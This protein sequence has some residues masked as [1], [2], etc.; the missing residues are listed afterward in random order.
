M[1]I[2][3]LSIV[4]DYYCEIFIDEEIVAIAK[5]NE[6]ILLDI[7]SGKHL[8]KCVM[9]TCERVYIEQEIEIV[10]DLSLEISF[11]DHLFAH[12]DLIV[13]AGEFGNYYHN[14]K[15]FH[16]IWKD[17]EIVAL[18]Q[19]G[20]NSDD[21]P[22]GKHIEVIKDG[23]HGY[24]NQVGVPA[25]DKFYVIES[26]G[27]YGI[28]RGLGTIVCPCVYDE[29]DDSDNWNLV[30]V[31][32]NGLW[33]VYDFV[34]E[35][36]VQE[37]KY[38]YAY[39]D[40][41]E[42]IV[43]CGSG[44]DYVIRHGDDSSDF[45]SIKIPYYSGI[46][47]NLIVY[48]ESGQK[49][50]I[51]FNGNQVL[52]PQYHA[53]ESFDD[54]FFKLLMSASWYVD[55][56]ETDARIEFNNEYDA[57]S[58]EVQ[59]KD[60][61]LI[62]GRYKEIWGL[63]DSNGK[64]L[65]EKGYSYIDDIG[66]GMLRVQRNEKWGCLNENGEEAIPCIYDMVG[67][68]SFGRA[69]VMVGNKWGVM[70]MSGN[71]ILPCELD[72]CPLFMQGQCIISRSGKVGVIDV[73]GNIVIPCEYDKITT[74]DYGRKTRE[75]LIE[76]DFN[77]YTG[78]LSHSFHIPYY[79]WNYHHHKYNHY[80]VEKYNSWGL[81]DLCGTRLLPYIYNDFVTFG[82]EVIGIKRKGNTIHLSSTCESF[83]CKRYHMIDSEHIL[84]DNNGRWKL[85]KT[86]GEQI[87]D[88]EFE[89]FINIGFGL[90]GLKKDKSY[91]I[92]NLSE[93]RFVSDFKYDT[94]YDFYGSRATVIQDGL[95]GF[96]D[97]NGIEVVPCQYGNAGMFQDGIASLDGV[98]KYGHCL[99]PTDLSE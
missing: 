27:K 47:N 75:S 83:V 18:E 16:D 72:F 88:D 9:T 41:I 19:G 79:F 21:V 11:E 42:K 45:I 95:H 85:Y 46:C 86:T 98:D 3:K 24:L 32:K 51:D 61:C 10:K 96:I 14:L 12:P 60:K 34:N 17:V 25:N 64:I 66:E 67:P 39:A 49:G 57:C 56:I 22:I 23:I 99:W 62:S 59:N 29:I 93:S 33:G 2:Y 26:E 81:Y 89:D 44:E 68:F 43:I 7:R 40:E 74:R 97:N 4:A 20:W 77:K 70:D 53:I 8:L 55:D 5:R 90:L 78:K 35:E 1:C 28:A 65:T 30:P 73:D 38:E 94:I 37:C 48:G 76:W 82:E 58:Y 15:G 54:K 92:F 69:G 6:P 80:Y 71:L 50:L 63:A 31:K 36:V 84:T 52:V 91:A 87:I 13:T